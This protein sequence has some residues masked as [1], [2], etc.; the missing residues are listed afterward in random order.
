MSRL[1][2]TWELVSWSV[3]VGERTQFPFGGDVEGLLIYTVHGSMSATLMRRNRSPVSATTL[4]GATARE[5]ASAAAGYLSY[6]GTYTVDGRRVIH[7][8]QVSLLPNWVGHDQVRNIRWVGGDLEL[9]SEPETGRSGLEI[10]N[11]LL[12]R[13]VSP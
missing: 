10:V 4:A 8:V 2:G 7:H 1:V 6:G 11:R 3:R 13:R 12:W 9:S 5:R